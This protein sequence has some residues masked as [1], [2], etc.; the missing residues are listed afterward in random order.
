MNNVLF[1]ITITAVIFIIVLRVATAL[2]KVA[3]ESDEK[4]EQ[5]FKQREEE[6]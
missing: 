6:K 3:G 4:S 5:I 1:L 2:C